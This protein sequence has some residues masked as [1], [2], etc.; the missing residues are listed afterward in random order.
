MSDHEN[1]RFGVSWSELAERD[2]WSFV[3][4]KLPNQ[5]DY[6][7]ANLL[8]HVIK[9]ESNHFDYLPANLQ[10]V[11]PC[12]ISDVM[13]QVWVGWKTTSRK[14][15][16]ALYWTC[17]PLMVPSVCLWFQVCHFFAYRC[18]SCVCVCLPFIH[19]LVLWWFGLLFLSY[20]HL[21]NGFFL[22]TAWIL[23]V[24][25]AIFEIFPLFCCRFGNLKK[26]F[27]K[28]YPTKIFQIQFSMFWPVI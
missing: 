3:Q 19:F 14:G 7:P 26:I 20:E 24:H 4:C 22:I 5:I 11:E 15:W 6:L 10:K 21:F 23:W 2:T 1:Q 9:T 18:M 16:L 28:F 27:V 13:P 12:R 17:A 25:P 8:W